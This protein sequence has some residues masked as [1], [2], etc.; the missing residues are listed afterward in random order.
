MAEESAVAGCA[1]ELVEVVFVA[2]DGELGLLDVAEMVEDSK[3][4]G[5][6]GVADR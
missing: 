2:E 3:V 4:V 6:L 5:E 1:W